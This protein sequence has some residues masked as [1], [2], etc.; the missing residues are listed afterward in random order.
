MDY[1]LYN[2]NIDNLTRISTR[3]MNAHGFLTWKIISYLFYSKYNNHD[4][5]F[6]YFHYKKYI[7][8]F[9]LI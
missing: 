9:I 4:Y 3:K 8:I 1:Y 6:A 5:M 2:F 7:F